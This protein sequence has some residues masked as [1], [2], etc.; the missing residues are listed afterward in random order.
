MSNATLIRAVR[1]ALESEGNAVEQFNAA[2][3]TDSKA[4]DTWYDALRA[5]TAKEED[6][7]KLNNKF[8]VYAKRYR[9]AKG[10]KSPKARA[11][12]GG[13]KANN[14]KAAGKVEPSTATPPKA[15]PVQRLEQYLL[16][17]LMVLPEVGPS[18]RTAILKA[19]NAKAKKIPNNNNK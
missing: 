3:P 7:A 5:D 15:T 9:D 14:P 4:F 19:F 1:S 16:A 2:A 8:G 10:W 17:A 12:G 6:G 18:E 11:S 13:R